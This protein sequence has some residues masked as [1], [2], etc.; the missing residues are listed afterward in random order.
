MMLQ[1]TEILIVLLGYVLGCFSTAYYL[2][3]LRTGEDIRLMGSGNAGG[4]NAKT[5]LGTSGFLMVAF[6]DMAKGV[7]SVALALFFNLSPFATWL[8]VVAVVAGHIWP[9]Q[10]RFRGGKGVATALGAI[11]VLN[12]TI[13]AIMVVLFGII[14]FF[15]RHV[16]I[17]G[18][19]VIAISPFITAFLGYS[20]LDVI[21]NV[22]LAII[23]I[24]AHRENIANL[25]TNSDGSRN[26]EH[27]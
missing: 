1:T 18:L 3:K 24:V 6:G 5:V 11:L 27:F 21:G 15:L 9:I 14:W 22:L 19:F 17:G 26:D 4:R 2:V 10:L 8:V 7:I 16:T 23:I 25:I 20:E 12:S 13:I